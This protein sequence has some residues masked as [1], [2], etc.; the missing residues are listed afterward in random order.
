MLSRRSNRGW[1]QQT[2]RSPRGCLADQSEAASSSC[3]WSIGNPIP[4]RAGR[5][6]E[7]QDH[8]TQA[9]HPSDRSTSCSAEPANRRSSSHH[10]LRGDISGLPVTHDLADRVVEADADVP[11]GVVLTHLG[12]IA[13]VADVVADAV[14]IHILEHLG[15][16]GVLLGDLKRLPDRAGIGAAAT[17]YCRPLPPAVPPGTPQ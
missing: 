7:A 8:A 4:P 15:L 17:L 9:E 5:I 2:Q 16:S 11:L 12:Q 10:H 3:C 14:L 6:G 1:P 13:D